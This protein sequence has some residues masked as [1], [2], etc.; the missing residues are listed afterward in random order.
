MSEAGSEPKEEEPKIILVQ[1][2][3]Q[4]G[5]S[6]LMKTPGKCE[7]SLTGLDGSS[8]AYAYFTCEEPETPIQDLVDV[9]D[10]S[11]N[12]GICAL[13]KYQYL[14]VLNLNKNAF[15]NID[16]VKSLDYLFEL[17]AAGN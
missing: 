6:N 17:N 2:Q 7:H 3:I 5:L 11:P 9:N 8:Y 14:R 1:E 10:N 4:K 12:K 13:E 16:K 15:T